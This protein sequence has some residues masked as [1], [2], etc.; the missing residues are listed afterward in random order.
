MQMM[1]KFLFIKYRPNVH[2]FGLIV[3]A[4][5]IF[6]NI[7][8]VFLDGPV[9]Q[10]YW[11]IFVL[12]LYTTLV[13]S[14]RPWRHQASVICDVWAHISLILIGTP[15]L[16]FAKDTVVDPEGADEGMSNL[17][18]AFNFTL[19]PVTMVAAGHMIW[20]RVSKAAL[21]RS[22]TELGDLVEMV[23]RFGQVQDGQLGLL[24]SSLSDWDM[25]CI[26]QAKEIFM[27]EL[28]LKKVTGWRLSNQELHSRATFELIR[29]NS[30]EAELEKSESYKAQRHSTSPTD[31]VVKTIEEVSVHE[32]NVQNDA[33]C[34]L[35]AA[36]PSPPAVDDEQMQ[37][38]VEQAGQVTPAL[39]TP[40]LLTPA[41]TP[42]FP[43][44]PRGNNGP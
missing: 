10:I 3:I 37:L 40:T 4:K 13:I 44:T 20:S 30:L 19:W 43:T 12:I 24:V 32:Q 22:N 33:T 21:Q 34:K 38:F 42:R 8:S 9:A 26:I 7:G 36:P 1:W 2:Y 41:S 27:T 5:G 35:A 18:I 17:I 28:F 25:T 16:W 14:F 6:L 15:L 39:M 11:V 23:K 31:G 29:R